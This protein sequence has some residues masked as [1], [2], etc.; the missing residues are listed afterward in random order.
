[1]I[2]PYIKELEDGIVNKTVLSKFDA[3]ESILFGNVYDSLMNLT[4]EEGHALADSLSNMVNSIHISDWGDD[5]Y[6]AD[7]DIGS[8]TTE[9]LAYL[10]G[11][12]VAYANIVNK[13][14]YQRPNKSD[15]DFAIENVETLKVFED[16]LIV[17]DRHKHGLFVEAGLVVTPM[18]GRDHVCKLTP[19]GEQVIMHCRYKLP[20]Y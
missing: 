19:L 3:L 12:L 9:Q 7:V 16:S 4:T 11:K 14:N 18:Y 8:M 17:Y 1:M 13:V 2:S 5:E 15:F 10:K 20:E 6:N